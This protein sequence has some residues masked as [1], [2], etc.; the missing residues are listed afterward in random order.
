MSMVRDVFDDVEIVVMKQFHTEDQKEYIRIS[1][2]RQRE[3]MLM[4]LQDFNLLFDCEVPSS[5]PE[6]EC[7][8]CNKKNEIA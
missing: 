6:S 8:E 3:E 2:N 7:E 1:V 5:L 4:R